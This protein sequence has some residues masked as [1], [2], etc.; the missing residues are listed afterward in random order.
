METVKKDTEHYTMKDLLYKL[1]KLTT[2]YMPLKT[3]LMLIPRSLFFH[4]HF[5]INDWSLTLSECSSKICDIYVYNAEYNLSW[6]Q[7]SLGW[8]T[9][10]V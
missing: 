4:I 6:L 3:E 10:S 8:H 2:L 5:S 1:K 7:K 9:F